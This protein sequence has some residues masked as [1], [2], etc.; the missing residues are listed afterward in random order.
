MDE[1][2]Q[3]KDFKIIKGALRKAFM[4]SNLRRDVLRKA[5]IGHGSY[6]CV[7]C[8]MVF[9]MR[10]VEIDHL[11]E[12]HTID[13]QLPLHLQIARLTAIMFDPENLQ[14]LCS[15]CHVHKTLGLP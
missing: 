10:N 3:Q 2:K 9:P 14:V 1:K 7:K 11:T 8:E 6:R 15:S 13:K 4:F 12:L 5:K